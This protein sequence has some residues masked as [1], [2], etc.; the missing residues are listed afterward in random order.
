MAENSA[1]DK[2]N[3]IGVFNIEGQEETGQIIYNKKTGN[4]FLDITTPIEYF[5]K[6]Y[7]KI[8]V[9]TGKIND[10]TVVSLYNNTCIRDHTQFQQ[11]QSLIFKSKYFIISYPE[12]EGKKFNKY[13][14]IVENALLWSGLTRINGKISDQVFS[15]DYG[16]CSV[17]YNWF[18]YDIIFSTSLNNGLS[19][20][21][22]GE[23]VLVAERL[24]IE[25]EVQDFIDVGDFI[26]VREQIFSL[27][28]FA[29]RDNVNIVE[30][31][32]INYDDFVET[33][34]GNREYIK[35]CLFTSQPYRHIFHREIHEYNFRLKQLPDRIDSKSN[36]VLDN[37]SPVFN[38]YLSLFKYADM[39]VEMIFLNIVQAL[40]T[41]HARFI[42]DDKKKFEKSIETRFG[43]DARLEKIKKLLWSSAQAESH[44]DYIILYSRINDLLIGNEFDG[45]FRYFYQVDKEFVQ[46]V[47]DTRHY[48]THYGKSKENK[49]FKGDDLEKA[50]NV[51]RVL[52]EF[53]I[54]KLLNIDKTDQVKEFLNRYLETLKEYD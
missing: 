45:L 37:L 17:K 41:F 33:I 7:G 42:C 2:V 23:E 53:H 52:L 28:S 51:L 15:F 3:Y 12:N 29:I 13:I 47:V 16:D 14:C 6:S 27:I 30:Q 8:P 39:P 54:C 18:G 25:I 24:K 48:Y 49:V 44:V 11:Y 36:D 50:I 43:K 4:I 26:K 5:G 40:E 35:Y 38:L 22:R 1:T 31:F 21:P 10:G 20:F 19:S 32:L 46:K 34:S 9:I